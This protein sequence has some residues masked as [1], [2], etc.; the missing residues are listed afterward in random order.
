MTKLILNNTVNMKILNKINKFNL[1]L[2]LIHKDIK[3]L[4]IKISNYLNNNK[5]INNT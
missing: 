5:Q 2:K 3:Q 1:L 4:I